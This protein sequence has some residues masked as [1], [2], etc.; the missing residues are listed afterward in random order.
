MKR[1]KR[2]TWLLLVL[3]CS[4]CSPVTYPVSEETDALTDLSWQG[5]PYIVVNE[6]VPYFTDDAF[7][8]SK[9]T[10]SFSDLDAYGRT[11]EAYGVLSASLMPDEDEERD[12]DLSKIT[13][14]GWMQARYDGIDNGGWLYNRCHLIAWAL[15]EEEPNPENLITG[16]RYLNTEGMLPFELE[17]IN[18][19]EEHPDDLLLYR[20]TPVYEGTNLLADGVL[21]EAASVSN[22]EQFTF[23]VY[24][25]NIQPGILLNYQTG[26]SCAIDF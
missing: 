7:D 1:F 22:P 5:E 12:D 3:L 6:N 13:P 19:L 2:M 17:A 23:C 15:S 4:A 8:V 14:S 9:P 24:L 21:L 10:L 25:F 11:G 16:T 18:W 20:A 26:D